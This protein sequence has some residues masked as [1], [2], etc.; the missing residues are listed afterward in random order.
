MII[1]NIWIVSGGMISITIV[2]MLTGNLEIAAV[3]VGALA[4]WIGG[5]KNGQG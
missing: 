2:G 1:K 3:A 4:G 5:N